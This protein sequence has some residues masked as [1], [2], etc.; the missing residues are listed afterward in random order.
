MLRSIGWGLLVC[1]GWHGGAKLQAQSPASSTS[2]ALPA[3]TSVAAFPIAQDAITIRRHAETGKPFTVAGARGIVVGQQEGVFEQW[4]LPVKMLS[5]MTIEADV[6]GYS[7]PILLNQSA[8]EIEVSPDHTVI[9]YTHI[10]FTLRQIMFSPDESPEGTGAVVMFQVD[11]TRSVDLTFRFTPEMR[12]MWV[13]PSKG[14]PGA[15]W[16]KRGA[17][18]F[19]VLHTDYSDFAGAVALPGALPG[20]MAPY[21]EKP[22]VHPLEFHLHYNPARDTDRFFPLLVALGETAATAT[23]AA[24]ESRLAALGATLKDTYAKHAARYATMARQL[25]SIT[26]PDAELDADFQ[27][28]V[29]SIEQLKA[30]SRSGEM[31]LVAGYYSSGD[32][33]RPGFGWYFGRDT[34]YTMYALNGVG[35][36]KLGRAAL[37]FL[38]KRQRA[39]GKMMHEYSQT[40]GQVDWAAFPYLYASADG[41]PLFLTAM[42]DYVRASGDLEF[43]KAH[44]DEVMKAWRF[45]T[46]HDSDGDGIYDNSEGT[47]WVESWPPGMPHQEIYLALLDQQASAAMGR[48]A[49]LFGD[50][51]TAQAASLRATTL[52]GLIEREYYEPELDAYAFSHNPDGSVDRTST[53][54]PALAWWNGAAGLAH[55][56]PTLRRWNS[57]DFATDWGLRDVAESDPLYDPISY[58]QGSV[59]PLFTGWAS[60]A[61]YRA[62]HPLAGYA[63]MMTNAG[64]TTTQDLGAVTELLSGAFFTPFGRSTSHQLWSSAMV[65]TPVLRGLFGIEVDAL[66]KTVTVEPRLPADWEHAEVKRLH[67]GDA[68]MDVEYRRAGRLITVRLANLSGGGVRLVSGNGM[69]RGAMKITPDGLSGSIVLPAVEVAMHAEMPLPGARTTQVKVL[70]EVAGERTLTLVMEGMAGSTTRLMVRRNGPVP[71]LKVEGGTLAGADGLEVHFSQGAGYREQAVAL[72]W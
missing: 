1:A 30:R 56:E 66:A 35:D 59:W 5:Q 43:L 36:F 32:S 24:L 70:S 37:E 67:V 46:T 52:T 29:T 48:L 55:A 45:E 13:Q 23:N 18:G 38:I 20:I 58:H 8:A 26:T 21:Q 65:L 33:A 47:G 31:G 40:A 64:Q 12:P 44:R 16:V 61:N 54:Y 53:I 15:E 50:D 7:V 41:T 71:G 3:I 57:H 14:T 25:T 28:A 69:T 4:V 49:T 2:A 11:A 9:T 34:L 19:Y 39:D 10:A 63:Q 60:V 42:L 6:Q 68:V 51:A 17:S 27:W 62:G 72:R 22:Q